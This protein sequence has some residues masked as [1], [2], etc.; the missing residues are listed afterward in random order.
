MGIRK[1]D[2][3]TGNTNKLS[4]FGIQT[5]TFNILYN[6]PLRFPRSFINLDID[7]INYNF[8]TWTFIRTKTST[9]KEYINVYRFFLGTYLVCVYV[10]TTL[11]FFV[12]FRYSAR[13]GKIS[14]RI[15]ARY[16]TELFVNSLLKIKI[17]LFPRSIAHAATS[18]RDTHLLQQF[19]SKFVTEKKKNLKSFVTRDVPRGCRN[20]PPPGAQTQGAQKLP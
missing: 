7:T 4:L 6:L 17:L 19:L 3:P 5:R 14:L 2:N 8:R 13:V 16:I 12:T 10:N 1:T 18:V 9:K 20:W 11:T 15:I